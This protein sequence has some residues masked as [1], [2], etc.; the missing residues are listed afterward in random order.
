MLLGLLCGL[1][2][3]AC[4]GASDTPSPGGAVR[5]V[6]L[7]PGYTR[8]LLDLGVGELLVGAA[9]L[10]P[11]AP[12][13]TPRVGSY[14]DVDAERLRALRPTHVLTSPP[15]DALAAALDLDAVEVVASP[16]PRTL[17]GV[18]ARVE[19]VAA[20]LGADAAGH[21]IEPPEPVGGASDPPVRYLLAFGTD[22]LRV[23]G[24]ETVHSRWLAARR[25]AWVNAA[26]GY[27]VP[28]P[29]LDRELLGALAVDVVLLLG[30]DDARGVEWAG[31]ATA[32]LGVAV[33]RVR[34]P[35]ALL[36]STNLGRVFGLLDAAC[37][38]YQAQ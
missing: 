4:G 23:M 20:A 35:E 6:T 32:E 13:G 12:A 21:R 15:L 10:D 28:A 22:P 30:A 18:N 9:D 19:A 37:G 26:A 1:L 25:P 34:D 31:G 16:L 7:D 11:A 3:G 2:V 38:V 5:V 24:G 36:V 27:R 14:L 29:V 8:V 17:A 33:V